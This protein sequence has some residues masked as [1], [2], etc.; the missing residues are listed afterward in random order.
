M[1]PARGGGVQNTVSRI[2]Q[3]RLWRTSKPAVRPTGGPSDQRAHRIAPPD[4][5]SFALP[6]PLPGLARPGLAGPGGPVLRQHFPAA[7]LIDHLWQK[8]PYAHGLR[9]RVEYDPSR[10]GA[11]H[12]AVDPVPG[13]GDSP[14]VPRAGTSTPSACRRPQRSSGSP[15][16][17]SG[18]ARIVGLESRW[19]GGCPVGMFSR[20][21]SRPRVTTPVRRYYSDLDGSSA[22]DPYGTRRAWLG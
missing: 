11:R 9:V 2:T 5:P 22:V 12:E 6:V 1:G 13:R 19:S 20:T 15:C 17:F 10:K 14:T 21:R 8:A 16:E 4:S 18:T 3:R 7:T